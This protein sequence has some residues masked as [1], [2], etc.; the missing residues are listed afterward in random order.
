MRGRG[1]GQARAGGNL[2]APGP[3]GASGSL[4]GGTRMPR[5]IVKLP[6]GPKTVPVGEE[7]VSIGR[8]AENTLPLDIEGV[9]RRH[10]QILFVG[11]G[12][13]IVDMGSRNGTKVNGQKVPRAMLKPGDV[14]HVG[15]VDMVFEDAAAAGGAPA[16]SE[17]LDIE[18]LDLGGAQA[19]APSAAS[20]AVTMSMPAGGGGTTGECVLRVI[21]GEKKGTEVPLK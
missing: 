8:T 11:K 6:G 13:E 10:A 2:T 14:I 4:P 16:A 17:G 3:P 7:A 1:S 5:L 15:G 19:S 9:S 12:Y 20:A 18:E 21:D